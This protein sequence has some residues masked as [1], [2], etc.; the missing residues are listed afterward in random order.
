[1]GK[2][3]DILEKVEVTSVLKKKRHECQTKLLSS[4]AFSN[5]S[6]V[7]EKLIYYQSKIYISSNFSKYPT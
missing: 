6:K 7:F 2:L 5:L 4:S 3:P 1:M